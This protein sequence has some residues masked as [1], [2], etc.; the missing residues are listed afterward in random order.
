MELKRLWNQE[1]YGVQALMESKQLLYPL[2]QQLKFC[3]LQTEVDLLLQQM[4][5]IKQNQY[6]SNKNVSISPSFLDFMSYRNFGKT[7]RHK[8]RT[9]YCTTLLG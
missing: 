3:Q 6:Y 4:L 9:Y 5:Y 1:N 2:E 7:S 8:R